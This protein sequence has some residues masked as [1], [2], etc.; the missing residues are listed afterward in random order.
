MNI[1]ISPDK[2]KGSLTASE[3]SD[4]ILEGWKVSMPEVQAILLPLADGGEGTFEVLTHH[5]GGDFVHV[6]V[7]DPL[8][9][10]TQ[11]S[12]GYD[13]ATQTAFMEMAQASGLDKLS[14]AERNC[15]VTSTFGTGQMILDAWQRG[16]RKIM[17][18]IGGSATCDGGIGM[19]AALGYQFKDQDGAE[20]SPVGKSMMDIAEIIAPD[21]GKRLEIVVL[22]DVDNPL[23]GKDGA[24]YVYGPQKGAR[25]E[26]IS[27]LD[28]GLRHL[29]SVL[30][31]D[32][33]VEV[34]TLPGGGASGGLG[35]GLFGFLGARIEPGAA[36]IAREMNLEAEVANC[37]VVITGEG[38]IDR[39]TL[40]GKVVGN[41]AQLAETYG[42]PVIAFCGTAELDIDMQ[43]QMGLTYVQSIID[44]P[45]SLSEATAEAHQLL[46]IAAYN[47]ANILAKHF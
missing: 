40:H 9:R 16:A 12:Y 18:G 6:W 25:E 3:V 26:E 41:L 33:K 20:I 39:Q 8:F 28:Q 43:Q 30:K 34:H 21:V 2:F 42:K 15:Y 35:A 46:R 19:A 29:A 47:V 27:Q 36:W 17:I 11:A 10:W 14:E 32:L 7:Y 37:D 31:R 44:R 24:A 4:A 38:K 45:M 13:S 1:L 22:S 5:F 23:Y